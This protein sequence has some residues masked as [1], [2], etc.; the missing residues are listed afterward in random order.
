MPRSASRNGLPGSRK[1]T[2]AVGEGFSAPRRGDANVI[3]PTAEFLYR[4][5]N[6]PRNGV[7]R[8][9]FCRRNGAANGSPI[10]IPYPGINTLFQ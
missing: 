2:A 3:R 9:S 8:Y 7:I 10:N 6:D 1:T 4:E 5:G